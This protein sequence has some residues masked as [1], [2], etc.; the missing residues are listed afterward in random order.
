MTP[1]IT[2]AK[3]HKIQFKIHKYKHDPKHHSF[4]LEAVEKLNLQQEKVFKTLVAELASGEMVVA[5]IPVA[6]MLDLKKV[7]QACGEKK[8]GMADK[9]RVMKTTGYVLGGVSP[10][11]QKKVLRTLLDSSAGNQQTIF[12]SAGRRGLEIELTPDDLLQLTSGA[13]ADLCQ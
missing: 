9:Q 8:A 1:A 12:V 7:A 6:E 2:A 10:L 5:I 13:Y 11:G 3:K 4:G